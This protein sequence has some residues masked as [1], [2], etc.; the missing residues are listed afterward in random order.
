MTIPDFQTLMRPILSYLADGQQK[1]TRTVTNAMSDEF[2]LTARRACSDDTE[3]AGQVDGQ[4]G[5]HGL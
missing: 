5:W 2:G 4:P 3:R 1:S